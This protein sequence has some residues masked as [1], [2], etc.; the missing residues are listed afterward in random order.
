MSRYVVSRN[1]DVYWF[2]QNRIFSSINDFHREFRAAKKDQPL[3]KVN[4]G[5]IEVKPR[6]AWGK[7]KGDKRDG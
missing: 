3:V 5:E 7:L 2:K 1:E 4:G 6:A